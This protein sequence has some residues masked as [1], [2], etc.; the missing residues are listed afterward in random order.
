M[1]VKT[2]RP[3]AILLDSDQFCKQSD[4][5]NALFIALYFLFYFSSSPLLP[6]FPLFCLVFG[7]NPSPLLLVSVVTTFSPLLLITNLVISPCNLS[8]SFLQLDSI[9]SGIP[10]STQVWYVNRDTRVLAHH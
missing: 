6:F 10:V 7:I 9:R 5:E 1:A 8:S 3:S 4:L 2:E